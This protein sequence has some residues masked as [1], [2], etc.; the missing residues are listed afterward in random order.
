MKPKPRQCRYECGLEVQ[1]VFT[2]EQALAAGWTHDDAGWRC[3]ICSMSGMTD[4][5]RSAHAHAVKHGLP[6][7][8][9]TVL[10]A[11]PEAREY[12]EKARRD[13]PCSVRGD[14][15]LDWGDEEQ[16]RPGSIR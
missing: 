9:A 11:T 7:D 16:M 12:F 15:A 3:P 6:S 10:Y 1:S 5:A 4:E 14:F 13:T 2:D 8:D